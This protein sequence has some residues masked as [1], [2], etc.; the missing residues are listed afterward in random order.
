MYFL[1]SHP[2][3]CHTLQMHLAVSGESLRKQLTIEKQFLLCHMKERL[4][5][6]GAAE[7]RG[8]FTCTR[9]TGSFALLPRKLLSV[10]VSTFDFFV[11]T[12][13][14]C[15]EQFLNLLPWALHSAAETR[16]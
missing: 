14:F 6:Q 12:R 3:S 1:F 2:Y 4:A 10:T 7:A 11:D 9:T 16:T 8:G 13:I 5:H 15:L